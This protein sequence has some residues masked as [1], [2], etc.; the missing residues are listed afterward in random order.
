VTGQDFYFLDVLKSGHANVIEM[1]ESPAGDCRRKALETALTSA[2]DELR[3]VSVAVMDVNPVMQ[4]CA[5][6]EVVFVI[7]GIRDEGF[8]TDKI[9]RAVV[10]EGKADGRAF[11]RVTS[12][13]G[14]FGMFPFLLPW[15]RLQK[16][17]WLMNQYAEAIARYP[18]ATRFHYVGH[19]NGTW[20]LANALERYSCCQ[21]KR[22]VFAG[23]VVSSRYDWRAR[24][25]RAPPQV[26]AVVN[27]AATGDWVVAYFPNLFESIRIQDLGGA[28]HRG[29]E[30]AQLDSGDVRNVEYV[31]GQHSAAL[32][33]DNWKAIA[34]FV[35]RGEW[36]PRQL[37]SPVP[38]RPGH[39]LFVGFFGRFP[40]LVWLLL[41][42]GLACFPV[43]LIY[44]RVSYGWRE[45]IVT[46]VL[47]G[48]FASV[49]YIGRRI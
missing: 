39:S 2:P 9:G 38:L 23:S 36:P 1:D 16:V 47:I 43:F 22:I 5:I 37:P 42:C 8:W 35:V 28:G 14:Y 11:A 6:E 45:W 46:S 19:S 33:E 27:H 49:V 10:I 30:K 20:L 21:F 29:F 48:Y 4:D 26:E 24:I 12:T 15:E 31:V 41:M 3:E 32:Q 25:N 44:G 34:K 18:N 7:H 40:I 13:Y 17:E